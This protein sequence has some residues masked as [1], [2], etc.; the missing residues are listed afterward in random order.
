MKQQRRDDFHPIDSTGK[1]IGPVRQPGYY[2]G[3]S[4]LDQQRFWDART[5]E[6]VL[7]RVHDVPP[8]RF[9]S[10]S[11][12]RLLEIV[13]GHILP[14]DDRDEAHRIPIVPSIDQRL[15]EGRHDGYRFADMPPDG[16]AFRLGL[17]AIEEIA[18]HL[19]QCGFTDLAPLERD[20][21]LKSLHDRAP[22][23][24]HEIWQRLP[25]HRFW[26][27]LVQD[28]VEAYYAHPWAWD[29]IGLAGQLIRVPT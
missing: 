4:T 17:R 12:A 2:P 9:F 19:H 15:Y 3:F 26:V 25:V 22:A 1:V 24:G 16:D 27:M 6:T 10:P 23:A 13:C 7:K 21:I 5:R 29:E 14:Q 20:K 8:I 18:H 28:C 11:E